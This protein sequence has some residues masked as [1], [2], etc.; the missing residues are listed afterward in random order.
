M[1]AA[2]RQRIVQEAQL[3]A[4]LFVYLAVL[5]GGV[6][7]YRRLILAEYR[8]AYFEYGYSLVEALVLAKV[9]MIGRFLRIG[10]G[11]GDRPLIVPTLYKTVCF[12]IFALVF[13]VVEHT[14]SGLLKHEDVRKVLEG[15]WRAGIDQILAEIVVLF[16]AL[17]PLFALWELGSVLGEGRLFQV[18]FKER[19]ATGHDS[20]DKPLPPST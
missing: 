9:I 14:L 8:I 4:M 20:Q 17:I 3:L 5:L 2:T 19:R 12:S 18:F 10:E 1:K 11:F 6:T 7:L 16:V 15:L 13:R